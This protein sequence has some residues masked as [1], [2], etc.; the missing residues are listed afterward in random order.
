MS[1]NVGQAGSNHNVKE[2][3]GKNRWGA[4]ASGPI[5]REAEEQAQRAY[6]ETGTHVNTV[7]VKQ[8]K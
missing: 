1:M 3:T 5:A 4:I 7:S 8:V 2:P 6:V